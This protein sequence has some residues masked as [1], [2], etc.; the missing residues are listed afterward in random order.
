MASVRKPIRRLLV[1]GLIISMAASGLYPPLVARV[2]TAETASGAR[3]DEGTTCCCGTKDGRCCGMA[4]CHAPAR[5][6]ES[7]TGDTETAKP[8]PNPLALSDQSDSL[9]IARGD[10]GGR[11]RAVAYYS[12]VTGFPSLQAQHVRIQT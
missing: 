1:V 12:R 8:R 4:C 10:V 2:V 11:L 7:Q 5:E 3:S 6:R 9:G